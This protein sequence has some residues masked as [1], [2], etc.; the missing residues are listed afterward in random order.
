[1]ILDFAFVNTASGLLCI[2]HSGPTSHEFQ[3]L[4]S[5]LRQTADRAA[6]YV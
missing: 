2:V 4:S 3:I 1:M 5:Q 6:V